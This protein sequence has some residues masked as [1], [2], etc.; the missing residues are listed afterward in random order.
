MNA[1]PRRE[2][3][4]PNPPFVVAHPRQEINREGLSSLPSLSHLP[5]FSRHRRLLLTLQ[6]PCPSSVSTFLAESVAFEEGARVEF[7][8]SLFPLIAEFSWNLNLPKDSRAP[9]YRNCRRSYCETT[10]WRSHDIIYEKICSSEHR[11]E[12]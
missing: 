11:A 6:P 1:T 9:A 7:V 10:D 5:S 4:V 2:G 3:P 8:C 12:L